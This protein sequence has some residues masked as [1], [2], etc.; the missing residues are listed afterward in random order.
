MMR[1]RPILWDRRSQRLEITSDELLQNQP[2]S[3]LM[4]R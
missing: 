3:L 2:V 1:F 4:P